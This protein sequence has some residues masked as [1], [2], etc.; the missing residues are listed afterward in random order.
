MH[1]YSVRK[2]AG[3]EMMMWLAVACAITGVMRIRLKRMVTC[4][5]ALPEAGLTALQPPFA[6]AEYSPPG[7]FIGGLLSAAEGG[8]GGVPGRAPGVCGG[9]AGVA[10]AFATRAATGG[11]PPRG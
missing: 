1:Q 11:P 8:G 3:A 10:R 7:A 5:G 2:I 4:S 6:A 9:G